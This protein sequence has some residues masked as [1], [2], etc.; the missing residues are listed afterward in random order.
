MTPPI[1]P[2][3]VLRVGEP[4]YLY[5][6]GPLILRVTRVGRVQQ[7]QGGLWLDLEGLTLRA[8][9]SQIGSEPQH[10]VVRL[11]AIRHGLRRPEARS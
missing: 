4:D 3:D 9:G 5:G 10:A 6:T 1:K 11:S 7:L 8:D 2:G